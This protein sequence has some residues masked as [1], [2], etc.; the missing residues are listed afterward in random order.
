M[1]EITIF[2]QDQGNGLVTSAFFAAQSITIPG[3]SGDTQAN[4]TDLARVLSEGDPLCPSIPLYPVVYGLRAW[5]KFWPFSV[6]VDKERIAC[7]DPLAARCR[8]VGFAAL[9]RA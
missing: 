8:Q 2:R 4:V 1:P 5:P 3:S 9:Q 7:A 6:K